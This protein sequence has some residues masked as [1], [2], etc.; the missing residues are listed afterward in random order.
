MALEFDIPDNFDGSVF[1][2]AM[3]RAG[4]VNVEMFSFFAIE[5][6]ETGEQKLSFSDD[7]NEADRVKLQALLDNYAS[8]GPLTTVEQ[9]VEGLD[10][11]RAMVAAQQEV[12]DAMLLD[13]LLNDFAMMDLG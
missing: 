7:F 12:I 3:V 1:R 5:D 11:L 4:Y 8:Q 13:Q 2:A 10:A 9:A 6:E